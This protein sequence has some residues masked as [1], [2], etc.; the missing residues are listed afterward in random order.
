[1]NDEIR[2]GGRSIGPGHPPFVIA[3]L[4]GNHNGSLDRALEIVEACAKAGAD[5]LKLQTYT[6]ETMTL[7]S[8]DPAF[9][10][11]DPGGPW[12]GRS[13]HDLYLDAQTPWDWHEP[14]F[15]RCRELGMLAF[16][17]PFDRSAIDLLEGLRVPAYKV[18]SFENVDLP[19]IR[20]VART[21]KPM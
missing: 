3:E 15:A 14:I 2:I 5:A 12:D 4:S 11:C 7:D 1:M 21:G 6:P 18:A 17:T 16:S 13:L 10:V 9:V 19:L 8:R 20:S